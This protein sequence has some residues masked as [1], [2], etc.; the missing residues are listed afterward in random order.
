[1][2]KL[3]RDNPVHLWDAFS[4]DLRCSYTAHDHSDQVV[5]A[6]SLC[7]SPNGAKLYGGFERSIKGWDIAVPGKETTEFRT[8]D[9]RHSQGCQR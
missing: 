4:G 5:A 2:N 3:Y 8:S 7:F 6:K 9:T 1:M